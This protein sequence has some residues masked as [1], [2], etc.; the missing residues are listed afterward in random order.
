MFFLFLPPEV[1]AGLSFGSFTTKNSISAELFHS[2]QI[3]QHLSK[4]PKYGRPACS[5]PSAG[6][7]SIV[8]GALST[9]ERTNSRHSEHA[10]GVENRFYVDVEGF[11]SAA[12][13]R[14]PGHRLDDEV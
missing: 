14:Q 12:R 11:H 1:E 7:W 13:F 10:L 2:C 3:S 9:G 4:A 8:D 6:Q 5:E